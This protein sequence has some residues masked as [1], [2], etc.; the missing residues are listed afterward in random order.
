MDHN[1]SAAPQSDDL[2]RIKLALEVRELKRPFWIREGIITGVYVPIV[3]GALALI[4]VER[5]GWFDKQ[6]EQLTDDVTRLETERTRLAGEAEQLIAQKSAAEGERDAALRNAAII[7]AVSRFDE[8]LSREV[9][10]AAQHRFKE[11]L[12]ESTE[13]ALMNVDGVESDMIEVLQG[14]NSAESFDRATAIRIQQAAVE[15]RQFTDRLRLKASTDFFQQTVLLR[16]Q[17]LARFSSDIAKI[18]ALDQLKLHT[19]ALE[20]FRA[21]LDKLIEDLAGKCSS[22][23]DAEFTSRLREAR[24]G[25]PQK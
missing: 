6:R 12:R 9:F 18:E 10:G 25:G 15:T 13:Y 14:H 1:E 3:A 7:S 23:I 16:S 8:D 21:E 24:A 17:Q 19:D 4:A 20:A 22:Q 11:A 5:A 2:E